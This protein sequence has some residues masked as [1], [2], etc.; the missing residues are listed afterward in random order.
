MI[1]PKTRRIN[2]KSKIS[3]KFKSNRSRRDQTIRRRTKNHSK[4]VTILKQKLGE[5]VEKI[6]TKKKKITLLLKSPPGRKEN[7]I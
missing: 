1:E 2:E 7:V 3:Q 5:R 4:I 6:V